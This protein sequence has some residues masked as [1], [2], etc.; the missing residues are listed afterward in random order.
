[1]IE[2]KF[3]IDGSATELF[4]SLKV[5]PNKNDTFYFKGGAYIVDGISHY[6]LSCNT[7]EVRIILKKNNH[8]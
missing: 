7:H 4:Y 5:L 2:V 3:V 6:I 1:M 8:R